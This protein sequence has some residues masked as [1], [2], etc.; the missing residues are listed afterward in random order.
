MAFGDT[1][2]MSAV[3][4]GKEVTLLIQETGLTEVTVYR[5]LPN[6]D[7]L[8]VRG[9]N[10]ASTGTGVWAGIDYEAPPDQE[11]T[12][13]ALI[14]DGVDDVTIGPV[15]ASGSLD[16]GGDYI[17][18]IGSPALGLN[19]DVE[20]GGLGP[21]SRDITQSVSPVLNRPSPVVVSFGRRFLTGDLRLITLTDEDR[22]RLIEILEFPVIMWMPR[23][24]YGLE[25]P[26]YLAAGNLSEIRPSL[27]GS[28]PA[29][30]WTL[31]ITQIDRP[32]P[33]FP[34]SVAGQSWQDVL[35]STDLW[36]DVLA[37]YDD[38]YDL[39]GYPS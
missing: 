21:L 20:A 33:D 8:I 11:L 35:D 6:T 2:T 32:P 29:R 26:L 10:A 31:G 22:L 28:E 27:L 19:V 36:S 3:A 13:G 30:R 1:A 18:P 12:Y 4:S 39:A 9:A 38:F 25:Q 34:F 16:Y 7:Q 23:T 14:S 37:N 24:G 17:L 15:V 5:I